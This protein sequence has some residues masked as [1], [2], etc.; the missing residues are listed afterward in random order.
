MSV[1]HSRN[2]LPY[3]PTRSYTSP[4]VNV[5][6]VHSTPRIHTNDKNSK[7]ASQRLHR[8]VSHAHSHYQVHQHNHKHDHMHVNAREIPL[9]ELIKCLEDGNAD[10]ENG[11]LQTIYRMHSLSENFRKHPV[12]P[13]C[14]NYPGCDND[15][16][17]MMQQCSIR[18]AVGVQYGL[19]NFELNAMMKAMDDGE[20]CAFPNCDGTCAKGMDICDARHATHPTL[21]H[22]H[23]VS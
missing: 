10:S 13:K 8:A 1:N 4:T 11:V 2:V 3:S 14:C 18:H 9:G 7:P 5:S 22:V 6:Q 20:K 12:P 15:S 16:S 19:T 21:L 17:S 23:N